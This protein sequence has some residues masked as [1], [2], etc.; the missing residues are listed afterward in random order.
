V[1]WWHQTGVWKLEVCVSGGACGGLGLRL[2]GPWAPFYFPDTWA[3]EGTNIPECGEWTTRYVIIVIWNCHHQWVEDNHSKSILKLDLGTSKLQ[4][5]L[6]FL[7]SFLK[8]LWC[9]WGITEMWPSRHSLAFRAQPLELELKY[10]KGF[11]TILQPLFQ[12]HLQ[13]LGSVAVFYVYTLLSLSLFLL[14]AILALCIEIVF[15]I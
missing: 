5:L 13:S 11:Q 7:L 12:R 9:S 8:R 6:L 1:N 2:T 10:Q 4:V 15:K 14:P 3:L